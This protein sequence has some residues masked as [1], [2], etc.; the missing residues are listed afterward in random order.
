MWIN[1]KGFND[2]LSMC[3]LPPTLY[4]IMESMVNYDNPDP[5]KIKDLST[6]AKSK[7]FDFYYPVSDLFPKDRFEDLFLKHYMFRRI[8]YDTFTS[9]KLHLEIK[10]NDIM[11]KYYKMLEGFNSLNFDGDVETHIRNVIDSRTKNNTEQVNNTTSSTI[12]NTSSSTIGN[13]S[14][15][16]TT[17]INKF[18]DT[19]QDLISDITDSNYITEYTENTASSTGSSNST[20][21]GTNNTTQSGTNNT[22]TTGTNTD[23]GNLSEE[24]T[25][26]RA[27]SID[28]YKKYLEI[29]NNIYSMVFKECDSLFYGLI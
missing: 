13:T 26:K 11:P 28:E 5:V 27:D 22:N 12:G 6:Q 1:F 25:I 20:S 15:D 18:S 4:S 8:N 10:L 3:D 29:M 23:S 24:I 17:T 19:P 2:A 7:I 9:F 16:S 21:S 14:S